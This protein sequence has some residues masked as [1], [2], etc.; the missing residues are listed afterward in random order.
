M[1]TETHTLTRFFGQARREGEV[2][3]TQQWLGSVL[4]W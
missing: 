3:A 2:K 4:A 1:L